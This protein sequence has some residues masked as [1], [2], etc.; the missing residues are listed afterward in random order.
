MPTV[1]TMEGDSQVGRNGDDPT[2]GAATHLVST[3]ATVQIVGR[4]TYHGRNFTPITEGDVTRQELECDFTWYTQQARMLLEDIVDINAGEKALMT[5]WNE[6]MTKYAGLGQDNL[7]RV[8]SDFVES[9]FN[10]MSD[11]CL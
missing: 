2:N 9:H 11:L 7:T 8:L 3:P 10:A 5:M 6:H 4:M 1:D